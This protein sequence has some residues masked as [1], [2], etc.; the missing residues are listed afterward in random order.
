MTARTSETSELELRDYLKLIERR[1]W[2]IV[3][4]VVAMVGAAYAMSK[5]QTPVYEGTAD[6]VL[7][8]NTSAFSGESSGG[9]EEVSVETVIQEVQ[10]QP[11]REA[12]AA[13]L[14]QAPLVSVKPVGDSQVVRVR[15]E[16]T[17]AKQ[18]AAVANAY[19]DKFI[20]V[21]RQKTIDSLVATID[22]LQPKIAELQGQIA[23]LDAEVART[24]LLGRGEKES[25][26]SSRR[27]A[28][29]SQQAVYKQT[30]DELQVRMQ[31]S[32]GGVEVVAHAQVPTRPIKPN[33]TRNAL[34][35]L[36]VGLIFGLGLA[37]LYD[38]LDD[39]IKS[40][41]DLERFTGGNI[42]VL[43]IIPAMTWRS[44]SRSPVVA[45]SEPNLPAVEAYRTLRTSVQ[46]L[47]LDRPL[48]CVQV[49]SPVT[50][51]GKTTTLANLAVVLARA[52]T[53]V[54]VVD[55]DLRRPRIHE[56][57]NL[58]NSEGF[59]SVVLG[60]A[61]LSA[62][63]QRV[64]GQ[65]RLSVLTS[66]PIPPNP[67]ELLASR[68]TAEVL[69]A[70]R[71]QGSIVLLDCPPVVPVTDASV[72]AS[73]ADATLLVAASGTTTRKQLHR[74]IELLRQV[75]APLMG[76]V[77]NRVTM[78]ELEYGYSSDYHQ[79]PRRTGRTASEAPIPEP[80]R[81]IRAPSA[82]R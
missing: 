36:P 25:Q 55:C 5:A 6:F 10:S 2:I 77:F 33:P 69:A 37:F 54:I 22:K 71:T 15:A 61:P 19:V 28:L 1:K 35:A 34:V 49:S 20:E 42:P 52:G 29:V 47:G 73:S 56:C 26:I 3:I 53:N 75:D 4:A 32:P 27:E 81:S 62:A 44:R 46:F 7:R 59:T 40:K 18:A 72:L 16:S 57:F 38:Y 12:V 9:Q 13:Q 11:V 43:G 45:L 24:P 65:E 14:G 63:L 30:V 66:G 80:A 68:R 48:A 51:E 50:A 67:S 41:E 64:E 60:E 58:R 21:R 70:L 82:Q 79:V 78:A 76:L 17:D 31:L 23:A 74:A 8:P 39:S